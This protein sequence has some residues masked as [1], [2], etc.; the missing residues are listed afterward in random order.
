MSA[1]PTWLPGV[2][3]IYPQSYRY[4]YGSH[5]TLDATQSTL[6]AGKHSLAEMITALDDDL[7]FRH[8][9]DWHCAVDS[10]ALGTVKLY[11]SVAKT[12]TADD[13]LLAAMGFDLECGETLP[14]ATEFVSR[15]VSPLAIPL[16]DCVTEKVDRE[17][18]RTFKLDSFRR[19]HGDPYGKADIWR[20][21]V[22]LDAPA[23]KAV[24]V[25][26]CEGAQVYVSPYTL[27]Q[28]IA[29][30]VVAWTPGGTGYIAGQC[31]GFEAG[32]WV[33]PTTRQFYRTSF[34]VATAV[35]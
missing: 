2:N 28:H 19:G 6:N 5:L 29:G 11:G 8:S 33:D 31:L 17:K 15:V 7:V 12:L 25:G 14:A 16:Q 35:A 1:Y 4:P 20:F 34:L 27:S 10:A 26:Y 18:E 30:T 32:A 21:R 22:M 3:W 24:K 23:V 13:R 9:P